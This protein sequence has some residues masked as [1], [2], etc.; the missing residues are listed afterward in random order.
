MKKNKKF[1][2]WV[3]IIP[4]ERTCRIMKVLFILMTATLVSFATG[5]YSQSKSLTFRLE[6]VNLIEIFEQI[7]KQSDLK[8]AYDVSNI[9]MD[10]RIN[11]SVDDAS[12]ETVLAKV[13]ENTDLSFRVINHYVIISSKEN[14]L[15]PNVQQQKS[16]S[17]KVTDSSGGSLPGVS[18]VVKGTTSGTITDS[19]GN[20]SLSNVSSNST[21][22][23]SFVGMKLQEIKFGS[24]TSINV[25]LVEETIG[26]DEVV[27]VGYGTQK[28]VNLTGAIGQV[29]STKLENR[30]L[31]SIGAAL[32]GV[33]PG[34]NV[35]SNSV[36]GGEPG[37]SMNLNIRGMGSLSGGS[38]YVLVDGVPMD[39]NNVNQND[40]ESISVLKDAA[41]SAIYGARAPYGVILI[42]TK[43][44]K[45]DAKPTIT[46]SGNFGWTA[47]TILPH[48]ANSLDFANAMNEASANSG[49]SPIFRPEVID[50]IKKRMNDPSF[51]STFPDSSNPSIWGT[52]GDSNDNNDYYDVYY[53]DKSF[54]QKHD[55][56]ISG[57]SQNSSYYIGLGWLKEGGKLNFIND[58]YQR[59]NLI[60]NL[61]SNVTKW[62]TVK[63]NTKF[64]YSTT[65]YPIG[66]DGRSDRQS[67]YWQI[68]RAWPT[69][70]IYTPN[71][72]INVRDL[73]VVP[74]LINGGSDMAYN[75]DIWVTPS[76][77][78][79]LTKDWK[80]NADFSYNNANYKEN[81]HHNKLS[82]LSVD[83]TSATLHYSQTWSDAQQTLSNT[84]YM[85]SNI[86]SNYEKKLN[87]HYFNILIGGQS[88]LNNYMSL[89]GSKRN[90]VTEAVP[91]IS[92]ATGDQLLDDNLSHWSTL[93]VFGRLTYNFKE[94]YLLEVN[95]R[96]DGS[97]RF[98]EEKRWGFFPS[99]SA[100]YMISK[101]NFWE[102]FRST[103]NSF[104]VRGSFGSLGN[105]NVPNY[106]QIPIL[107]INT[108]LGYIMNGVR[109]IYTTYPNIASTGLSWETSKT[110]DFGVDASFFDNRLDMTFDWYNRKTINMFGP[111]ETLPAVFG[112]S[113]PRKNNAAL[114]T[115]GFELS[116]GWKQ[117]INNDLK[118]E[119]QLSFS[120]NKSIVT[121]Y[122]NPTKYIGNYYEGMVLGEIWGYETVGFYTSDQDVKDSPNQSK[123]Y[124]K[125]TAGDVK[126]KDLNGDGTIYNGTQ[127]VADHGD[128]KIM[129]N[130]T[131]RYLF[132][133]NLNTS[134]KNF[135]FGMFLQGVG[136]N[137]I[138]MG[139]T[140]IFGF[141]SAFYFTSLMTNHLDYW[142]PQNTNA[143]LPKPYMSRENSK[144][145][146]V[147]TKY[148]QDGRYIRLK[149]LQIGYSL[150]AHI[151]SIINVEKLRVYVSGENILTFSKLKG[152]F[153]PEATGGNYGAG[154]V[155]PIGKIVSF[156]IN[157]TLK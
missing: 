119:I 40:I 4:W 81:L 79:R 69:E 138:W 29:S 16:I 134:Y 68:A 50:R 20:Y 90:L 152:P 148:L 37:A 94:K 141:G 100:G 55:L 18:V 42:T 35:S 34:L 25:V 124:S 67:T 117:S 120:D 52:Y 103:I 151:S 54:R 121:Q 70:A 107:P 112:T 66:P 99:V 139:G 74:Y 130:S 77:E 133:L 7:E 89:W 83:K 47:P 140:Q 86:F 22:Q 98:G 71:G 45:K 157:V 108:N 60:S 10:Q 116:V 63:L 59:Y 6:K 122:N 126:Y 150:P 28:K 104:K 49:Q 91:S 46:Y 76:A 14:E 131:P 144:N 80:V 62:L 17:G 8:V 111:G 38:P 85:T 19:N 1:F 9:N 113:V 73:T 135:D 41:A 21:L 155:Y 72:D 58:Y 75:T 44:G 88:E 142:S 13:L 129:G 106:L 56:G 31:T 114:D 115:K 30:P 78:I 23:F 105:Q 48:L 26:I 153:D 2:S 39:M 11:I 154:R 36:N 96:Y 136:K 156:G 128:L 32:Q 3:N 87:D 82:M 101:E 110:I 146:L 5:S 15:S 125:W 65:K 97:S 102:S 43:Q 149:N 33:I 92:T 127:T 27:A 118:Y 61:S 24:Q 145:E 137:D 93:G 109:P 123:I 53:K 147:Q 84:Q 64:A 57:G 143:F 132:G 95:S 51:P 12:I